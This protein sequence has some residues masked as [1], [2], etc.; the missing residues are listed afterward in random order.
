[1]R[2]GKATRDAIEYGILCFVGTLTVSS[3]GVFIYASST[4]DERGNKRNMKLDL[5]APFVGIGAFRGAFEELVGGK[6]GGGPSW[7]AG[8]GGG[9]AGGGEGGGSAASKP[10]SAPPPAGK[11]G[12]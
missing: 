5:N 7:P 8:F 10:A 3:I 6:G 11:E 12:K 1:M 2:G 4:P 9:A